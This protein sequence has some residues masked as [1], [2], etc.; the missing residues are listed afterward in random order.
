V[1]DVNGAT[2][3]VAAYG[4]DSWPGSIQGATAQLEDCAQP[5]GVRHLRAH[6]GAPFD[7]FRIHDDPAA[8]IAAIPVTS[9]LAMPLSAARRPIRSNTKTSPRAVVNSAHQAT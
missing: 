1:A 9:A 2:S 5:A 3:M 8:P 4:T 6:I 7:P